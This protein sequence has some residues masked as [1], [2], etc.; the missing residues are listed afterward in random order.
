MNNISVVILTFNE[1][2]NISFALQNVKEWADEVIILDSYS[3]DRTVEIAEAYGAKV[4]FRRFDNYSNQRKYSLNKLPIASEW[5]FVLDADEVL[6]HELKI[7]IL[8]MLK[9]TNYDAFFIKRRFYWMGKWIKRGYYPTTVLRFGRKGMID[10]DN[11]PIN[12]HLICHSGNVGMLNNDFIDFNRK[13]LSEWISK[14]NDYSTREAK[15]L[16]DNE[17]EKYNFFASQYERK[18]WIRVN[19]WNNIPPLVRPFFYF[20]YRYFI[21]FGFLDGKKAFAYHFLHAF[22]YKMLID[23]KYLEKKWSLNEKIDDENT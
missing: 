13:N 12:E 20:T 8:D 6:T 15:Q 17:Y 11:R 2:K 18:R 7:E 22:I 5:I 23:F 21:R 10:C 1:E 4:Y 3:T 16:I 9:T 14:H 19:I